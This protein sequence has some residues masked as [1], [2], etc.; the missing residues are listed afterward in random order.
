METNPPRNS[1]PE[2]HR[3]DG[4][5]WPCQAIL[6]W[7]DHESVA[8]ADRR[9]VIEQARLHLLTA[10][11]STVGS[12]EAD[13]PDTPLNEVIRLFRP[14]YRGTTEDRTAAWFAR[15]LA[16]WTLHGIPDYRVRARALERPCGEQTHL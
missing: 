3:G 11:R 5:T 13:L 2:T 7:F 8:G 12:L 1:Q 4:A 16:L 9:Q 6:Q 14:A 10:D 15:W